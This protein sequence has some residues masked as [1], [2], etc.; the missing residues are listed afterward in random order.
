MSL[1]PWRN[2]LR[3]GERTE[4]PLVALRSEMDRLFDTFLREPLGAID[5]PLVGQGR[6]SPTIDVAETDEE[7]TVRAELPGMDPKDLDVSISGNQLVLSGEK[8]ESSEDKGK[9]YHHSESL[10]GSFRR[11]VRLPEGIDA[12]HVDAQY[13]HGVLTLHLKKTPSAVPKRI[14]VKVKS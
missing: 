7:V 11:A 10:Y 1:I 6:W 13:A 4:S 2:K 8:K 14:E 3:E 12:E 5:W 9:D